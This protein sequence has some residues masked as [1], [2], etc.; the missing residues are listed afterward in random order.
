MA[1]AKLRGF[2]PSEEGVERKREELRFGAD[3][4]ALRSGRGKQ[5]QELQYRTKV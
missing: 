5:K 3:H 2:K 1:D 4:L